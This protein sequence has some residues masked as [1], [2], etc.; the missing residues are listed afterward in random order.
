MDRRSR[1]RISIPGLGS[2][3]TAAAFAAA[4]SSA[5]P[6]LQPL[7]LEE[8]RTLAELRRS[9][10]NLGR[11]EDKGTLFLSLDQ[12]LRK[13]RE[14]SSRSELGDVEQRS[15]LEYVL[16]R[17]V[18]FNFDVVLNELEHGSDPEHVVVAA[19]ALGFSRIPAP[20]E[21]GGDPTFPALHPRAVAPLLEK[22][23]SSND[24]VVMNAL[25][26]V[27][28]I[29]A[30]ETPRQL[31]VELMVKHHNAGVRANAALALASVCTPADAPLVQGPLFS[32]LSDSD[33]TVRLHAVKALGRLEDRSAQGPLIE[34]LRRDDTP[35]VRACAALELGKV[36]D[37]TAVTYL[38]EG[39]QSDAPIV[40]FQCH[41][42]LVRLTGKTDLKGYRAWREW[43]SEAPENRDRPRG[44]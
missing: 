6:P 21:P 25:L 43:W 13:W 38:I 27:G 17:E 20:D 40:A 5:E 15:S 28:R 26:S 23:E 18:Y 30:P 12:N 32:S 9:D 39:L 24:D 37:W 7:S 8:K 14:L 29:A 19:A 31:L 10:P 1:L 35:L 41:K 42:T 44:A 22:I 2:L 3:A 36:G 16:T 34:R 4:C 33:P 11:I